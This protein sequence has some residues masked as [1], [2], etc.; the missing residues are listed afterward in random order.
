[1]MRN[2][3]IFQSLGIAALGMMVRNSNQMQ[4]GSAITD[5]DSASAITQQGSS[6]EYSPD[7]EV[8]E[9]DEVDDIVVEKEDTVLILL[10]FLRDGGYLYAICAL[11]L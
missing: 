6:S 5:G 8:I 2:N 7:D 4:Q 10:L 1:M 3:R 11:V 9:E